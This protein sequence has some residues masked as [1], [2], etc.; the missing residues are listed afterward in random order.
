MR[1]SLWQSLATNF[2]AG[3]VHESTL[4]RILLDCKRLLECDPLHTTSLLRLNS[5]PRRQARFDH[6]RV[7]SATLLLECGRTGRSRSTLLFVATDAEL[8]PTIMESHFFYLCKARLRCR[9]AN[10]S[11]SDPASSA[12]AGALVYRATRE[13]ARFRGRKP[14]C[15]PGA[16]TLI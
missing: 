14:P 12:Q 4:E 5:C 2:A 11:E 6:E 3:A 9:K 16:N 1:R 13:N 7:T 15:L 8:P 10:R